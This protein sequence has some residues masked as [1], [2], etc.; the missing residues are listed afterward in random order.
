[1]RRPEFIAKHGG[2]PHGWL[3]RFVASVMERETTAINQDAIALLNPTKGEAVLDVGT[4]NGISLRHLATRVGQGTVVGV[5]HS[6]VMCTRAASNNKSLIAD[7]R[8]KVQCVGSD[9]LPFETGYF[10]AAMS[11]HTLYFWNPAEPHLKEIARVLR[12]GGRL[13]LAFRPSSDPATSDFPA[14]VYTFRSIEEVE[15]LADSCG[16]EN[17]SFENGRDSEV[18]LCATLSYS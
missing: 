1:M 15:S 16:F 13:V 11:V 18:L 17:F 14:S 2:M 7:G 3:G 6:P 9:N 4:G 10:D 12:P 5:D 8:V